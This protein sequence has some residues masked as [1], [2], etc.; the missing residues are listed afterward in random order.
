MQ[1]EIETLRE[2]EEYNPSFKSALWMLTLYT[3][4]CPIIPTIILTIVSK[5][6]GF[7][8]EDPLA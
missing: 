3:L 1:L 5:L 7:S 6:I 4:L 2:K 8:S